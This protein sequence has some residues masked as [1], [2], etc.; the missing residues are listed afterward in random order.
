MVRDR[1]ITKTL[2]KDFINNFS[3]PYVNDIVNK[4]RTE[5]TASSYSSTTGLTGKLL[6]SEHN[7]Q[8]LLTWFSVGSQVASDNVDNK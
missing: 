3:F 8:V 2:I 4:K 6:R 5:Q 7:A 1:L